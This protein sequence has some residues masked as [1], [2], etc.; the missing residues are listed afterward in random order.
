MR[1][2]NSGQHNRTD[3]P[4]ILEDKFNKFLMKNSKLYVFMN[5]KLVNIA[6]EI[7]RGDIIHYFDIESNKTVNAIEK[8]KDLTKKNN[9]KLFVIIFPHFIDFKNYA[10]IDEH[11]WIGDVLNQYNISHMDLLDVYKNYDYKNISVGEHPHPN[12][13]GNEIAAQALLNKLIDE[14][15]IPL[16]C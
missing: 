3:Y 5:E 9:I 4:Y 11:N 15:L 10:E 8:I 6:R 16:K 13:L 2:I 1:N 12:V 7:G 14:K